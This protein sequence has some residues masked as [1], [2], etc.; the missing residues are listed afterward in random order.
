MTRLSAA[1]YLT[2]IR[3]ESARFR[4]VLADCDTDARVPSCPDWSAGDLLGHLG[5]VQHWWA[6]MLS[7]RPQSP[8]EM[9]YVELPRPDGHQALLD[10]FDEH[11]AAF[12]TALASA[13]PAEAAWTW[14]SD[15]TVAFIYRRQAHEAL[16]HRIDAELAAGD[17]TP[18]EP[19]LAAD[20]VA[21]TLDVMYGGLPPWG[22]FDPVPR[23]LE[24]RLT[25][26]GTSLWTQLGTFS[27]TSPAGEEISDEP[28][29]HLVP[30][31]GG[32]ADAVVTGTAGDIDAWLWHRRDDAGIS[33][34]GDRSAY[35]HARAVLDQP[36]N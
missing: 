28:D 17:V 31:P 9:G 36:I 19:A 7:N 11:H 35:D 25:D 8:D 22:R 21:E 15:H 13:D 26:A 12:M 4:E 2:A 14:S 1:D 32:A 33:V 34:T 29:M 20:G 5:N 16:I 10:A 24:F 6:A 3:R 18:L 30:D 23:Y 27:G